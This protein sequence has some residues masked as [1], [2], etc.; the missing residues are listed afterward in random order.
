MMTTKQGLEA[1]MAIKAALV[2]LLHT[3]ASSTFTVDE[4]AVIG[5]RLKDCIAAHIDA[6]VAADRARILALVMARRERVEQNISDVG[7]A[8]NDYNR[9]IINEWMRQ[10]RVLSDLSHDIDDTTMEPTP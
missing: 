6:A 2:A 9:T 1:D 4:A 5:E 8:V 10:Y 3:V 7:V